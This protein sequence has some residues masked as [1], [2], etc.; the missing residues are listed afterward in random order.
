MRKAIKTVH[1]I[2]APIDN[3]WSLIETGAEWENWLPILKGSRV[4]GNNR[5]CNLENGDVLEEGFLA[6]QAEKT[7]IYNVHKQASFP[8]D[9]IVAIMRLEEK[10]ANQTTLY[11]S[12]DLD[13]ENEETYQALK[14]NISGIY[15]ASATQLQ[16]LAQEVVSA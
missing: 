11:W 13:V 7:F 3:V 12:V 6:S 2:E 1:E 4:E 10:A 5:I 16:A 9:N 14:E 15:A 8:A